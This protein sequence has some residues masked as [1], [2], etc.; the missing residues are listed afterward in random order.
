MV[1]KRFRVVQ[2]SPHLWYAQESF[3]FGL[4]WKNIYYQHNSHFPMT[5][6]SEEKAIHA[7]QIRREFLNH[8][9]VAKEIPPTGEQ[10][11]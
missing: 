4:F 11:K 9:E 7:I 5:F 8:R 3:F 10:V 1:K 6:S 2:V